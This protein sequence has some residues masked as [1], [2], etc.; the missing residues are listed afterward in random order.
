MAN[1]PI[2][3]AAKVAPEF[4]TIQ[5]T[6]YKPPQN[7]YSHN[8]AKNTTTILPVTADREQVSPPWQPRQVATLFAAA[9]VLKHQHQMFP[10]ME[11]SLFLQTR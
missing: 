1:Q 2:R 9:V 5:S 4:T 7:L 3:Q 11:L 8:S 6:P 10:R